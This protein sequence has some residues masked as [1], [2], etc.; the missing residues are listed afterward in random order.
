[1][2]PAASASGGNSAPTRGRRCPARQANVRGLRQ[3]AAIE[4]RPNPRS[5]VVGMRERNWPADRAR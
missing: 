3:P 2:T 1:V 4:V 5:L